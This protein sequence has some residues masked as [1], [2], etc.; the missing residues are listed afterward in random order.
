MRPFPSRFAARAADPQ[1]GTRPR[2]ERRVR[3]AAIGA[4]VA[5]GADGN[6]VI[7][8]LDESNADLKVAKCAN[9][10]CTGAAT[11]TTLDTSLSTGHDTSIAIGADGNPIIA[12]RNNVAG[13]LKLAVCGSTDCTGIASVAIVETS[14]GAGEY[15]SLEI[16]V[17]GLPVIAHK[18]GT[19]D[20]LRVAKCSTSTCA[21]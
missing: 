15:A 20:N 2:P 10:A 19:S 3:W 6:P 14:A 13:A 21:I 11:I 18:S 4:A 9:P 8:Y 16:G 5:I 1:A 7:A 17:D 12:Y